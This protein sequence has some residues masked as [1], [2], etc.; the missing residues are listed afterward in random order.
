MS[1]LW[2]ALGAFMVIAIAFV[3]RFRGATGRRLRLEGGNL[4]YAG[5]VTPDV[6]QRAG[7]YL[8]WK[9]LFKTGLKD[10]RLYRDGEA[11]QLQLVC[12]WG[13]PEEEQNVASEVLAAGFSDDVLS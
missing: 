13:Q 8:E 3:L 4:Y 10:A 12:S 2:L 6:A 7:R 5:T 9:G 1:G 11:Y